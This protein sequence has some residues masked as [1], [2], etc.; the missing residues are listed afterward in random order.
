VIGSSTSWAICST[1]SPNRFCNFQYWRNVDK[2]IGDRIE[3][4]VHAG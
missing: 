1:A 4:G 2:D 3:N